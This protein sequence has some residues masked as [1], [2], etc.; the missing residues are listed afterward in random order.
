MSLDNILFA[1]M[2][3][4]YSFPMSPGEGGGGSLPFPLEAVPHAREKNAAKG[5]VFRG[6]VME[7]VDGKKGHPNYYDQSS[8]RAITHAKGR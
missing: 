4:L 7:C 1:I 8:S 6:G 2:P 5:Y 3:F